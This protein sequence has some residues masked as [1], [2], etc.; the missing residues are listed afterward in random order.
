MPKMKMPIA[1]G[2][3]ED[4]LLR[5]LYKQWRIPRGQYKSHP[6]YLSK[7]VE[8]WNMLSGRTDPDSD[9]L[10]YFD[11]QQ[12]KTKKLPEPWPTFDNKHRKLPPAK[13][14][15]SP[16]Q[17][18]H[19]RDIYLTHVL[20]LK[21]GTDGLTYRDELLKVIEKDFAKR[22][23]HHIPGML[24]AAKIEKERKMGQWLTLRDHGRGDDLGFSDLDEIGT[25]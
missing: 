10:H 4:H 18:D 15:L 21:I 13:I 6:D 14:L 9:I 3:D 12:K 20:P 19:L 24:L 25:A 1:L 17:M 23:G 8:Q 5:K 11:T 2:A 22:T 16:D 7:F